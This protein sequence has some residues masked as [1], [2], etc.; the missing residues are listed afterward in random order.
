ME[1]PAHLFTVTCAVDQSEYAPAVLTHMFDFAARHG[2]ADC[3]VV[4]VVPCHHAG[5]F[6]DAPPPAAYEA[7]RAHAQATLA[8]ILAGALDDLS[9][10]RS[11]RDRTW[12]HVRRGVPAEEI[13]GLAAE[14]GADLIVVGR[15]G[16][17][18]GGKTSVADRVIALAECPVFV[19]Q[20]GSYAAAPNDQCP[21]CV[22]VRR[23]TRGE[24]WFCAR[25]HGEPPVLASTV[26][27]GESLLSGWRP[28]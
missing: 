22:A 11:Q 19:V 1:Q 15:F 21:D 3:H 13:V 23:M 7:E 4:T 17:N 28:A 24:E 16:A 26:N 20:G 6:H 14:A 10:P 12:L 18:D 2:G 5:V 25:H 9:V 8:R 27:V